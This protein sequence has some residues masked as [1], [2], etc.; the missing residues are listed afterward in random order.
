MADELLNASTTPAPGGEL[1]QAMGEEIAPA[2]SGEDMR[3]NINSQLSRLDTANNAVKSKEIADNN[4]L[5]ALRVELL[6][7]LF[8][9]MGN[10]G[11]DV[12]DVESVK[13]FLAR[14]EAFDPD[15]FQLFELA[16]TSLS[17]DQ[18]PGAPT[19]E[20]GIQGA[21]QV[22]MPPSAAAPA[23]AQ[24]PGAQFGNIMGAMGQPPAPQQ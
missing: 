22:G 14:L 8:A 6:Q 15:L 23:P 24:Q 4:D 9:A 1:T 17:G 3:A 2:M 5:E 21:P 20:S 16:F 7:S 12:T 18:S 10:I 13:A 19:P 11:V